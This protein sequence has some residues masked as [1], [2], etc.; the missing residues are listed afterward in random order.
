MI[1]VMKFTEPSS[2]EVINN[3]MPI[4]QNVCPS[5]CRPR[6]ARVANGE[7]DVHPDLAAPPGMKKLANITTPPRK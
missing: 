3:T 6:S 2:D 4:S 7:Y 5:Q 1:V